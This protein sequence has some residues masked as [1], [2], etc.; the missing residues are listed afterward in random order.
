MKESMENE[1]DWDC[2][3]QKTMDIKIKKTRLDSVD[4]QLLLRVPEK[5]IDKI[6]V[7]IYRNPIRQ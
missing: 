4:S 1:L 6:N 5:A 3:S 2:I 7:K